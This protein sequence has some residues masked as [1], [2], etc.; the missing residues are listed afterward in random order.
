VESPALARRADMSRWTEA[1]VAIHH[2]VEKVEEMGADGR[3]TQAV[4]LLDR[5]RTAVAN[6]VDEEA[7]A[8]APTPEPHSMSGNVR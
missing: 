4:I 2:A 3:L 1:E 6:Y 5:A 7:A 8:P